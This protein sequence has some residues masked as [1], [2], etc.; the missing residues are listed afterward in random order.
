[1]PTSLPRKAAIW[2][3]YGLF[4]LLSRLPWAWQLRLGRALG[5]L[6][7]AAMRGPRQIA[8]V[9]LGLCFPGLDEAEYAR[10]LRRHFTELGIGVFELGLAWWG[11][12]ERL[13]G[14][15]EFAGWEHV[16][17]AR[18]TGRGIILLTPHCTT[19][20]LGGRLVALRLP[21]K[22]SFKP[23]RDPLL[24]RLIRQNRRAHLPEV[25]P[26]DD[27]RGMLRALQ[28][29]AALWYAPDINYKGKG[30]LF[31]DFF[32]VPAATS[33]HPARIAASGNALVVPYVALRRADGGY[34][35]EVQPAL[36]GFPSGDTERDTARINAALEALV[37]RS[38]DNY[39]W[40]MR[41]FRTRPDT[42]LSPYRAAR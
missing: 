41:R 27:V 32:G 18:A 29:G 8:R 10:R 15:V 4:R 11:R 37:R 38:P 22:A 30:R 35:V 17:A 9:N 21:F 5:R 26:A 12:R 24:D 40:I 19:L 1:M 25:I 39:L 13:A 6:L 28:S 7:H 20:E 16:E 34:R 2:S 42:P 23:D 36:E 33:P 14:M 31:A 3:G